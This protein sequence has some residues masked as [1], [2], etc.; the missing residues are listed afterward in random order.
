VIVLDA[1]A[2]LAFLLQEESSIIDLHSIESML[3]NEGD[4]IVPPIFCTEVLNALLMAY[5]RERINRDQLTEYVDI[6]ESIPFHIDN[7]TAIKDITNV[8]LDYSL[9]S[10]DA[11]YVALAIEYQIPVISLDKA[12]QRTCRELS[13]AS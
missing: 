4:I 10:Y 5:K 6:I 12:I 9:T 1:S 13:L 11:S 2:F 7:S 3:I 8:A